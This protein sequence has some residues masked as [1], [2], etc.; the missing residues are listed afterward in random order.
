MRDAG[1][2][3]VYPGV[4]PLGA[5]LLLLAT[6]APAGAIATGNAEAVRIGVLAFLGAAAGEI[7]FLITTPGHYVELEAELGASRILTLDPGPPRAPERSIGSAVIVKV[8][9]GALRT[10]ADLR[11]RRVAVVSTEGFGGF[12]TIWRELA[13]QDIDPQRDFGELKV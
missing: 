9:N 4:R 12:Q 3:L 1:P 7:D 8:G 6:L 13:A 11:G 2:M 10:L 5:L